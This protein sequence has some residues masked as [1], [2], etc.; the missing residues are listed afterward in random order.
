[1]PRQ[2]YDAGLKNIRDDIIQMGDLAVRMFV[3]YARIFEKGEMDSISRLD[4]MEKLQDLIE[5]TVEETATRLITLQSPVA[6]DTREVICAVRIAT[7]WRKISSHITDMSEFIEAYA[8]KIKM[9]EMDAKEKETLNCIMA[10][11]YEMISG[12]AAAYA[13]RDPE[14]ALKVAE[15][16]NVIDAI[17]SGIRSDLTGEE[18]DGKNISL[19][20]LVVAEHIER[21]GDHA[22]NICEEV[23]YLEKCELVKLN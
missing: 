23:I 19:C 20:S 21:I 12:A 2:I 1:M 4:E 15:S 16:D 6:K 3:L 18:K 22:A 8:R 13:D 7:N 10:A 17:Y 5:K 14:K 11:A 9:N